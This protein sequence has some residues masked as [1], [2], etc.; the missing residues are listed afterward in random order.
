MKHVLM[1]SQPTVAGVAQ[2]VL[3]WSRG[4]LHRGWQVTVACPSD[5]NLTAWCGDASIPTV[6]WE[7]VRSPTSGVRSE[8]S[9]LTEI[10]R[11]TRPDVVVLHSSKA[12]L[13]GRL[14]LRGSLPTVFVPHAWSFD[15][16]TGPAAHGALWW[17]RWAG[18][19]WTD[20]IV[21]VSAAE[22]LRGRSARISATYQVARNGIDVE[23]IAAVAGD[24]RQQVR[25]ALHLTADD[26]VA[27]CVGRL[28][29]QKGQDVLLAAWPQVSGVP[30]K[31]LVIVGDGPDASALHA[32]ADGDDTVRFTGGVDRTTALAWLTAADIVVVPSRWE[33]M[34]LV[35]LEA[36]AA[37]TPVVASDVTGVAE[38]VVEPVGTVVA[39]E[40]PEALAVALTKWLALAPQEE[41][42]VRAQARERAQAEF[43]LDTTV[44][45]V[46]SALRDTLQRRQ[47]R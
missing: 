27:V 16:A 38:A 10:I 45:A 23:A 25:A 35:P 17:E 37:G 33:G 5:E 30:G 29:R 15:A 1:V 20:T 12:G 14:A 13:D 47:L 26:R 22:Y 39:P 44:S 11:A 41:A 7:A 6:A 21:C 36:L 40:D 43:A 42:V 9:A 46:E 34:A 28:T 19:R 8:T 31:R 4:L 18:A 2:C 24:G 3:D 32:Q